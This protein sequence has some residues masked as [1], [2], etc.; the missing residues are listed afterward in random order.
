MKHFTKRL[1]VCNQRGRTVEL[2]KHIKK[3]NLRANILIAELV[4]QTKVV[5]LAEVKYVQLNL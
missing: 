5:N 3:G 4:E 1:K 2:M